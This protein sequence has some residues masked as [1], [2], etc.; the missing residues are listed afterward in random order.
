VLADGGGNT[1]W[2]VEQGSYKYKLRLNEDYNWHKYFCHILL[3]IY[4]C[5]LSSISL[6]GDKISMNRISVLG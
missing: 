5:F 6:S 4:L 2:V 1:E 3:K